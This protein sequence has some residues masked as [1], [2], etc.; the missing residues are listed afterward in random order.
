M[1]TRERRPA[2]PARTIVPFVLPGLSSWEACLELV[3]YSALTLVELKLLERATDG[4]PVAIQAINPP[5][6]TGAASW[7]ATRLADWRGEPHIFA[8]A[9]VGAPALRHH[10]T[11]AVRAGVP[12]TDQL[13]QRRGWISE[14]YGLL[15]EQA[16]L[17]RKM[18]AFDQLAGFLSYGRGAL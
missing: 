10:G 7:L 2:G 1:A 9:K 17:A 3:H 5:P 6:P 11:G 4:D 8:G 18:H 13:L 12:V 16:D 15:P 14:A